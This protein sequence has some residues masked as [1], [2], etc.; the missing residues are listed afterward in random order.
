MTLDDTAQI[1]AQL[2]TDRLHA[3][4]ALT[5][6]ERA[7]KSKAAIDHLITIIPPSALE[8]SSFLSIR[9]EINLETVL[10]ILR[11]RG[12]R[13]SLPAVLNKTTIEFRRFTT[14]ETLVPAGFGT[15]APSADAEIVDPEVLI[16]PLSVFDRHGGRIGYGAGHYDRALERLEMQRPVLKIGCAFALQEADRVPFEAH[17]RPLDFVVTETEVIKC[18]AAQERVNP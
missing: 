16:I 1:K 8:V 9:S 5:E 11:T 7:Q 12:H 2:R 6:E 10:P 18:N 4:D 3:R 17:D 14:L 15:R 13:V